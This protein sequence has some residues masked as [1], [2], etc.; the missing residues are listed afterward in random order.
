MYFLLSEIGRQ[1]K[2]SK[3][4][5]R[6]QKS[7]VSENLTSQHNNGWDGYDFICTSLFKVAN[8]R[9]RR[10]NDA[11]VEGDNKKAMCVK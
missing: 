10:R 7:L 8:P 9:E 4:M 2:V 6:S 5:Y 3:L 1:D 11:R